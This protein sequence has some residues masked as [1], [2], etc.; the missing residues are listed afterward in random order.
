MARNRPEYVIL[1]SMTPKVVAIKKKVVVN[2][3]LTDVDFL[4]LKMYCQRRGIT[5]SVLLRDY[6]KKTIDKMV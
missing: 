6:V 3:R 4:K 1:Y 5:P 2:F